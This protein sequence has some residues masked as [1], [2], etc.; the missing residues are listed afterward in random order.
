MIK[1]TYVAYLKVAMRF[2]FGIGGLSIFMVYWAEAYSVPC[3]ISKMEPFVK[4][5]NYF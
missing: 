1:Y 5:V 3:R 2:V 4:T